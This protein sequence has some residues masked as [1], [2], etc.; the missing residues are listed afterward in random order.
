MRAVMFVGPLRRSCC[1]SKKVFS[2]RAGKEFVS[3]SAIPAPTRQKIIPQPI[4][5]R[6]VKRGMNQVRLENVITV[7]R[8]GLTV[9]SIK[10]NGK[11]FHALALA[12]LMAIGSGC[13]GIHASKSI[14][15]LDF[16]L[17]GLL[18]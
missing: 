6:L 17:P 14:S 13:S 11:W 8:T 18:K 5:R 1:D 3:A 9:R 15:P 10:S 16:F 7:A 2:A 4:A 12:A